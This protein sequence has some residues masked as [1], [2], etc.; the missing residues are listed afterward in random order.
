MF[1]LTFIV[2]FFSSSLCMYC[3]SLY[4]PARYRLS[5]YHLLPSVHSPLLPRPLTH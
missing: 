4:T 2:Q 5:S 1:C 3:A